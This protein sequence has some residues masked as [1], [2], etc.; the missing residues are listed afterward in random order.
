MKSTQNGGKLAHFVDIRACTKITTSWIPR[1]WISLEV[2]T[3]Q[4]RRPPACG[5]TPLP[6]CLLPCYPFASFFFMTHSPL[7]RPPVYVSAFAQ[8]Q[9][10]DCPVELRPSNKVLL[11]GGWGNPGLPTPQGCPSRAAAARRPRAASHGA[12]ASVAARARWRLGCTCISCVL[13]RAPIVYW[14]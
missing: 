10:T 5:G 7:W 6:C 14:R 1:S 8:P 3:S 9:G 13:L 4:A 11:E 12:S 2:V